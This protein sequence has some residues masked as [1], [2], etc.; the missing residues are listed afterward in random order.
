MAYSSHGVT[1]RASDGHQVM[2][3]CKDPELDLLSRFVN[4]LVCLDQID[5][6]VML[7]TDFFQA[8]DIV[9]IVIIKLHL[10]VETTPCLQCGWQK[11][12]HTASNS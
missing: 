3:E 11:K 12:L 8:V 2:C 7:D 9:V 6:W 10:Q 1:Y 4:W 5:V